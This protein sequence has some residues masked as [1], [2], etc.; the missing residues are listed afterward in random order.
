M[1]ATR[2]YYGYHHYIFTSKALALHLLS[3]YVVLHLLF[4]LVSL[5]YMVYLEQGHYLFTKTGRWECIYFV[6]LKPSHGLIGGL[7]VFTLH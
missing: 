4:N 1:A 3:G 2:L 5:F 6:Y 7:I